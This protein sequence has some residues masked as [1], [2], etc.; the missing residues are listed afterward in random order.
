MTKILPFLMF[1]P[2]VP[3]SGR[4]TMLML[5][6]E[7]SALPLQREDKMLMLALLPVGRVSEGVTSK[8]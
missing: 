3:V 2:V 1:N 8:E 6:R 5:P 4:A 7:I